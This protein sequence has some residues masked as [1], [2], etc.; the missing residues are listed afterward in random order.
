MT[1][2]IVGYAKASSNSLDVRSSEM[3]FM[4]QLHGCQTFAI[5]IGI[6]NDGQPV[7]HIVSVKTRVGKSQKK[8]TFGN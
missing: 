8:I 3:F 6:A 7:A 4:S 2:N 5:T 1:A